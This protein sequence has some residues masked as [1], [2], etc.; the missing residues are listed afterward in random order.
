M[1]SAQRTADEIVI[2]GASMVTS[3]G[4]EATTSCAAARAGLG[5]ATKL[6]FYPVKSGEDGSVEGVIAHAVPLLTEGFE[7]DQ[8]LVRLAEA[9]FAQL[10]KEIPDTISKERVGFYL[11]IPDADRTSKSAG[12]GLEEKLRENNARSFDRSRPMTILRRAVARSQYLSETALRCVK[13][14]GATGFA[15][16]LSKAI[17][18]LTSGEVSH[19]IVGGVDSLLDEG[20]LVWLE[21][22]ERLKGP[23]FPSGLQPGEAAGFILL[24]TRRVARSRRARITGAVIAVYLAEESKTLFSGEH[25]TGAGLGTVLNL[26][27]GSGSW[28]DENPF[29]V[30]CDQNGERYRALEWGNALFRLS[31]NRGGSLPLAIWYPAASFGDTGSAFGTVATGVV[32]SAFSRKYA[33]AKRAIVTASSEWNLR[34]AIVLEAIE[35]QAD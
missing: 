21:A 1:N 31:A 2:T 29:W 12:E 11:S 20:T 4:L 16:A 8:R 25:S 34:A 23:D 28:T 27:Y 19:A 18:D 30:I 9:A 32:L 22:T 10:H 24:E 14:T 3:L 17:E 33:P 5:R 26:A 7:G 6:D 15:Q 13:T 35:T